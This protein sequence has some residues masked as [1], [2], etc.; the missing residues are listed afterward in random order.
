MSNQTTKKTKDDHRKTVGE[1]LELPFE[2]RIPVY[3]RHYAWDAE[4]E[5]SPI[6]LF[7][8]TVAEQTDARL[9]G[10][11]PPQHYLGAVLVDYKPDRH[12]TDG[13]T[14]Y[15][16]VD[17]QQRLTTIQI[18]M[19]ALTRVADEHGC[20]DEIK[21]SLEKYIFANKENNP[22]LTRLTPTNFDNKQ[23]QAVLFDAYDVIGDFGVKNVSR[24]NASKSKIV[25]AFEFFKGEQNSL[26][27]KRPQN[28]A[29]RAIHEIMATLTQG[30][31][32]VRIVLDEDDDAQRVFESLN[33]SAE[34]LTT[35]DLIRNNVFYRASSIREGM[36]EELFAKEAWQQL[37][38]PY[39]EGKAD[40]RKVNWATHIEAY[41]ARMLVAQMKKEVRF[42]RNDIFRAYKEFSRNFE[43]SSSIG[44]EIESLARYADIYRYL[45]SA[46]EQNPVAPNTDFGIFRYDVW[47]KRD[48]YPVLFCIVGGGASMEEKQRMLRLLESY[49]IRRSVCGLSSGNY[50]KHA[51]T[52][53]AELGDDPSYEALAKV[54]KDATKDTVVF[55]GKE[56]VKLACV[57]E[58]FYGS[59]FQQYIF[60]KIEKSMHDVRVERLIVDQ[61]ELTIDHILPQGWEANPEWNQIVLGD[62]SGHDDAAELTVNSY[63]HTIGNLT[64]MSGKNNTVKSNQPFAEVKGLLAASELKLNRELAEEGVWN[65]EKIAA[66]SRKLAEKICEIWPYDIA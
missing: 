30:F 53:C 61:G 44:D 32:L 9:K 31:D 57:S 22:P 11:Q 48:F 65:V 46:M 20:G 39:W 34:P 56:R 3:Q 59:V 37:E 60:E 42:S 55:P 29:K 10:R 4:K 23:F 2:W 16:V 24:E 15:D 14:R 40:N 43:K 1:W 33:N 7:W 63:L 52:I 47:N 62:D 36:D 6:H 41:V 27:N 13:M 58:K 28:E 35:F 50:N 38:K 45:D 66:R 51:V 54:L 8:E 49:V 21:K 5:S 17:G 12:A 25:S 64:M 18:A 19:L 26:V